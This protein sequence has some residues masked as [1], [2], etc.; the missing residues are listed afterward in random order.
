M[1]RMCATHPHSESESQCEWPQAPR[2]G[3]VRSE[4]ESSVK[5][6]FK[7]ASYSAEA[8]VQDHDSSDGL[9]V[10]SERRS[11]ASR[12]TSLPGA[13]GHDQ[14][15]V[16]RLG[17]RPQC[18]KC[19]WQCACHGHGADAD[20]RYDDAASVSSTVVTVT[21]RGRVYTP[22]RWGDSPLSRHSLRF[23]V[24]LPVIRILRF[25]SACGNRSAGWAS[26]L[27]VS[28][29]LFTDEAEARALGVLSCIPSS[30]GGIRGPFGGNLGPWL[31]SRKHF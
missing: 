9:Q 2:H 29:L 20:P 19:N 5:F 7:L 10:G 16:Y 13:C 23:G 12:S 25:R 4:S 18:A 21:R 31:P 26:L 3:Q 14:F 24:H 30:H 27:L 11:R 22:R 6:G 17:Q 1:T 28:G 8:C 15:D